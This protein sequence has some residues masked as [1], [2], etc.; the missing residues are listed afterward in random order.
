MK[1]PYVLVTGGAGF[2]GAYLV[3]RLIKRFNIIVVDTLEGRGS[4]P[5]VH[6]DAEF[7]RADICDN[8]LYSQLDDYDIDAVYH[9][10]A[11]S[12]GEVS[13]AD[14]C[15]DTLANSYG[16]SRIAEYS[17]RRGIRRF[18]YTSSFAVYGSASKG[19]VSEE[20]AIAPDSVYGVT[21]YTGELLLGR[22]FSGSST[23]HTVFRLFNTYGPGENLNCRSKGMVSIYAG[24]IWRSEPV[25]VKGSLERFRDFTYIEDTVRALE[26]SLD[27]SITFGKTYNLSSSE[28]VRIKDLLSTMF[29]V[30]PGDSR[31]EVIEAESTS[32]D[33]FGVHTGAEELRKDTGWAPLYS[34][35]EGLGKYFDWIKRVPVMEDL[36]GF[37]PFELRKRLHG[38]KNGHE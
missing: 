1:K 7:I 2:I 20:A 30:C 28:K 6:P 25:L 38:G 4:I 13:E 35:E 8:G 23:K 31:R 5:Y 9:L 27:K 12:A 18:I 11:Q 29:K 34:L 32:G 36:Q 15:S 14:P 10:A 22:I 3:D 33:S 24:Y 19:T 16:T 17:R 37:H 26:M 21:K